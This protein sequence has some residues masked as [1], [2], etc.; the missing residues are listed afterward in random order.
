[1]RRITYQTN[2]TVFLKVF[3]A[4]DH[5]SPALGLGM[6]PKLSKNG[7]AFNDPSG[8]PGDIFELAN[9]WYGLNLYAV[10]TNQLGDLIIRMT[11]PSADPAEVVCQ[12]VPTVSA[13]MA[14]TDVVEPGWT[15][16]D[17][18]KMSLAALAGPTTFDPTGVIFRNPAQ[19]RN[20]ITATVDIDGNRSAMTYDKT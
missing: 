5:I 4:S 18:L 12:V 20:R 7:S 11:N 14:L 1:M 13:G 2:Y 17:V 19:T 16:Q 3:L 15:V 8:S 10:D 9:G 6:S